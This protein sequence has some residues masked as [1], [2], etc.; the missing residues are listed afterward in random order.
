MSA[1][2]IT[3]D[4]NTQH[5]C[6]SRKWRK[7]QKQKQED[8]C[9]AT[10]RQLFVLWLRLCATFDCQPFIFCVCVVV[11]L[12]INTRKDMAGNSFCVQL[13]PPPSCPATRRQKIKMQTKF[14][15]H[16]IG[17]WKIYIWIDDWIFRVGYVGWGPQHKPVAGTA[18]QLV[19][20][21]GAAVRDRQETAPTMA[22]GSAPPWAFMGRI[23]LIFSI[24][25]IYKTASIRECIQLYIRNESQQRT[26]PKRF[27]A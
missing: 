6:G 18:G 22:A 2:T 10:G 21:C 11:W 3:G 23:V 24:T 13:S 20:R 8:I 9:L 16:F 25:I 17:S 26:M 12:K 1:S 15:A 7:K 19:Q 27:L 14:S 5:D 4:S